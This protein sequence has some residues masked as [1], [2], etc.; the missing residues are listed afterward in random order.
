MPR[1]IRT[2]LAMHLG[3]LV[4]VAGVALLAADLPAAMRSGGPTTAMVADLGL[5]LAGL[6]G[7][8]LAAAR[9]GEA[10]IFALSLLVTASLAVVWSTGRPW[11][12]S[13]SGVAAAALAPHFVVPRRAAVWVLVGLLLTVPAILAVP[14]QGAAIAAF[15]LGVGIVSMGTARQM[16]GTAA[17][18]VLELEQALDAERGRTADAAGQ[19]SRYESQERRAQRRSILRGALTRRMGAVE[20]IARSIKRDLTNGLG[21]VGPVTLE[22]AA[23]RSAQRAEHLA[24]L[25]AGGRAREHQTTLPLIWPRVNDLIGGRLEAS[26]H[27]KLHLPTDLPPVVGS[28]EQWVQILT[29]LLDNAVESMPGGGVIEVKAAPGA[30]EGFVRISVADAGMGIAPEVLPHV[31]EPFYTSRAESGAEGLGLAMVASVVEG[32]DGEVRLSSKVGEGTT[33]EIEVP[34]VSPPTESP[35]AMQLEGN[36]LL[37]DD[38][39]DMRRGATKL[40]ESFGLK[41]IEC[42]SGTVARTHLAAQPDRFRI[43]VL[44]VVMPGTPVSEIVAAVRERKRAFPVLLISGYDTMHMVDAVLAM[45]GVRF[46]RKPFTREE[47]FAALSDLVSVESP[48]EPLRAVPEGGQPP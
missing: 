6:L 20:A 13:A 35:Q 14:A 3:D 16:R 30:R 28:G 19:V 10:P 42:D 32:M 5:A 1:T 21:A 31:M 38:D 4:T 43:A 23:R 45:G 40:L 39:P 34:A 7:H 24:Q 26:H 44:D 29:A 47:L 33:V 2:Q 27:L 41:V 15:V 36:V 37:A 12:A 8:R 17:Q 46:L 11:I 22:E 25:A 9:G 18:Q 48:K